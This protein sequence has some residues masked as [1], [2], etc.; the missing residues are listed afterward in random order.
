MNRQEFISQYAT[1]ENAAIWAAHTDPLMWLSDLTG[2]SVD[3]FILMD[4]ERKLERIMEN[5]ITPDKKFATYLGYSDV[6]PYEIVRVVSGKTIEIREMK[7]E[8]DASVKMEW[9]VGGF[10]GHCTN[11]S[12]QKWFITSDE[13]APIKR[14]RLGK[15]G[16]KDAHGGRYSLDKEPHKFYDYNF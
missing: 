10:S 7:A 5:V 6:T 9:V 16:W 1:A 12:E 14:I 15:N 8:R 13:A 4:L 3:A 11:Q 2:E